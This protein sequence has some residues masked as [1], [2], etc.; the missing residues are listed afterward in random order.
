MNKE[1]TIYSTFTIGQ[2]SGHTISKMLTNEYLN[3]F[4]ENE[5]K[6]NRKKTSEA[7]RTVMSKVNQLLQFINKEDLRFGDRAMKVGSSFQG[8]KTKTADEFDFN[9]VLIGLGQFHNVPLKKRYYGFSES[10]DE[11][12]LKTTPTDIDVVSKR[13]PLPDP[14]EGYAIVSFDNDSDDV[15]PIWQNSSDLIFDGDIIPYLV[16]KRLKE[17]LL[18]AIRDLDLR[19]TDYITYIFMFLRL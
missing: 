14:P 7:K 11:D 13:L 19:G 10:V 3:D 6:L 12:A 15:T 5:V 4:F 9:I 16:R 1:Y 8:L 18:K 17:L 2:Y